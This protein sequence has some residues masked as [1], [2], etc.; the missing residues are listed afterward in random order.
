MVSCDNFQEFLSAWVVG[1][2]DAALTFKITQHVEICPSCRQESEEIR[3]LIDEL[4]DLRLEDPG[5]LFFQ[6]QQ[7]NIRFLIEAEAELSSEA[8]AALCQEIKD[9][10]SSDPGDRFFQSLSQKIETQ[11]AQEHLYP[12][13]KRRSWMLPLAVAA[14]IILLLFG[15]LRLEQHLSVTKSPAPEI[16]WEDYFKEAPETF[17]PTLD[18][19]ELDPQQLKLLT[20]KMEQALLAESPEGWGGDVSDWD[21]LNEQELDNLI[22]HMQA[23]SPRSST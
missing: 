9:L 19:E 3:L 8:D 12:L 16:S 14:G 13:A 20:K 5:E 2:L 21:D 18:L 15:A 7:K 23:E 17:S 4:R 10:A 22:Q 11:V 6:R 1:G